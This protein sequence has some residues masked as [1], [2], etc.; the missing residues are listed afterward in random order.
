MPPDP[1]PRR[2]VC[3]AVN[4]AGLG[5]VTR[6]LHVAR[7]MRR[8]VAL[9]DGRTPELL[10]LTT[11]EATHLIT[12][13]GFAA[14]KLPSKNTA[15]QS[16]LDPAEYRRLARQFVWQVLSDFAP[17]LLVVDTFPQGSLD[18]LL[19]ILDGPFSRALVLRKIKP[20]QARRPIFAAAYR[21]YD[22]VVFPHHRAELTELLDTLPAGPP[23]TFTGPVF[24]DAPAPADR[25]ALREA[26]RRELGLAS[27]TPLVYLSAGG[28]GDPNAPDTLALLVATLT[29]ELP[30]TALLVGAGPLYRGRRLF[31]PKV[32]WHTEPNIARLFPA[33]DAAIA[34]AGY[35]TFHEL[36]AH[37]IPS[38]FFGLDKV[39]DD[40][41]ERIAQ[42]SSDGL[43]LALPSPLD[44]AV[45]ADT[46]RR[47]L[48]DARA[49]HRPPARPPARS[50]DRL[51]TPP[52]ASLATSAAGP[53][54]AALLAPLFGARPAELLSTLTP[55]L[56][57]AL[58]RL[59]PA[60]EPLC[61]EVLPRLLSPPATTAL[62]RAAVLRLLPVLS[63]IARAEL[64]HHLGQPSDEATRL[65]DAVSELLSD[66]GPRAEPELLRSALDAALR[67][68]PDATSTERLDLVAGLRRLFSALSD[69]PPATPAE[70]VSL[71]RQFPRIADL[72]LSASLELFFVT[73]EAARRRDVPPA[74]LARRLQLVKALSPVVPRARID[75]LFDLVV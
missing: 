41:D 6:L 55:R 63:P 25:P 61:A 11:T 51:A 54:A 23:L 37:G 43:C 59:G 33:V 75:T 60:A 3:Y 50:H 67:R 10:F 24:A 49:A 53:A 22:A 5:H 72:D 18:E 26:L 64:E 48:A 16:H 21:F 35:N 47:L 52:A 32:I 9:L 2:I 7:W 28:G 46:A 62:D 65:S 71:F 70:L 34:A 56:H 66:A 19:P 45:L 31:H 57:L 38:A 40:Q 4:G 42:A 74:G 14:F 73:L 36:L 8:L 30:D 12:D 1:R 13:A 29:R 15:R 69:H 44:A 39:A 20:E 58:D 27:T 68:H 17:D